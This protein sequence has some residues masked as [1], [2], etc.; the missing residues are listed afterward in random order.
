MTINSKNYIIGE[1]LNTLDRKFILAIEEVL[2]AKEEE[3]IIRKEYNKLKSNNI[4]DIENYYDKSI[5]MNILHNKQ[6]QYN[7]NIKN[8]IKK[9]IKN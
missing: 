8:Q 5:F 6:K 2:K 9:Y 7:E 4:F 3:K 1:D